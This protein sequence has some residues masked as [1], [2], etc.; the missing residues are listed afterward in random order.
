MNQF[1]NANRAAASKDSTPIGIMLG[2]VLWT[3]AWA[4][5]SRS[6]ETLLYG[7]FVIGLL[8]YGLVV[9]ALYAELHFGES[10][11]QF[12]ASLPYR[13]HLLLAVLAVLLGAAFFN[14][15][16]VWITLALGAS[17]GM[18]LRLWRYAKQPVD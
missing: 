8:W 10:P 15:T 17:L 11:K 7:G 12:V 3:V 6:I 13:E 5:N 14:W 16:P 9:L 1:I 2:W 4:L 18:G